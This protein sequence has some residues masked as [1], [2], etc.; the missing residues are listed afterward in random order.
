MNKDLSRE[1]ELSNIIIGCAIE[2]HRQLGP[3]LYESTYRD[4]LVYELEK[5]GL[6]V[7]KEKKLTLVYKEIELDQS[8]RID[9]LVENLVVVELKCVEELN[10]VHMSQVLTYLKLGEFRLGLLLNFYVSVMKNGVKRIVH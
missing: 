5:Q 6:L 7:E 1:N 9:I 10:N 2:V 4:C 3:G 8:F